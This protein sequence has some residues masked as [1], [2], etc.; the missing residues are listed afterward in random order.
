MKILTPIHW[1][2]ERAMTGV[3]NEIVPGNGSPKKQAFSPATGFVAALKAPVILR[4]V[5][6]TEGRKGVGF[7][8]CLAVG[9]GVKDGEGATALLPVS[10]PTSIE[11][12][13]ISPATRIARV[14]VVTSPRQRSGSTGRYGRRAS[15]SPWLPTQ[16]PR[17]PSR[18]PRSGRSPTQL[19][20]PSRPA[21]QAFGT[22]R[23]CRSDICTRRVGR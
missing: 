9:E 7:C 1:P 11:I 8:V 14:T 23:R 20:S 10:Q 2:S 18:G 16:P 19:R 12:A 3:V 6:G 22:N 17:F 15:V 21:L 5:A 4:L 13:A